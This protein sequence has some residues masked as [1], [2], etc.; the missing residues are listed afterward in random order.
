MTA[1]AAINRNVLRAAERGAAAAVLPVEDDERH[2]TEANDFIDRN[3][4]SLNESI[5]RSRREM[6]EGKCSEKSI[7]EIIAEGLRRH[8]RS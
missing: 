4:Q 8:C 1:K 3:R 5:Q 7:E 6:A 2:L